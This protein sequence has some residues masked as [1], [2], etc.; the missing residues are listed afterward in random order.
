MLMPLLEPNHNWVWWIVIGLLAAMMRMSRRFPFSWI[1]YVYIDFFRT[2]PALVQL[3]WIFYVLP[4]VLGIG[5]SPITSGV[6]ALSLPRIQVSAGSRFASSIGMGRS[7]SGN[8]ETTSRVA[9][10]SL[11]AKSWYDLIFSSE[12]RMS[13]PVVPK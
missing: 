4:I 3:I 2:T 5:L 12:K 7:P 1:A 11:F 10:H 6:I 8:F 13:W 9:F